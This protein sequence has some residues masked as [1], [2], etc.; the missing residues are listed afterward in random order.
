[1]ED[2]N[3]DD[4]TSVIKKSKE[5]QHII[6]NDIRAKAAKKLASDFLSVDEVS[7]ESRTY[8]VKTTLPSVVIALDQLLKEMKYRNIAFNSTKQALE[9]P[10]VLQKD[11]PNTKFDSIN[12]LGKV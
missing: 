1:M 11:K 12:W 4:T 10:D 2:T 5:K 9:H 7:L 3:L 6:D 8:L